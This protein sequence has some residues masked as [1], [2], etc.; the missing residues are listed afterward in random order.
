[1]KARTQQV[2]Q[3]MN[4]PESGSEGEGEDGD[5]SEGGSEAASSSF[6]QEGDGD[7]GG[8]L[9]D[10]KKAAVKIARDAYN[11]ALEMQKK[12]AEEAAKAEQKAKDADADAE[13]DKLKDEADDAAADADGKKA[14][15]DALE[16]AKEAS[17]V[18]KCIARVTKAADAE[19]S[20]VCPNMKGGQALI[21]ACFQRFVDTK[22]KEVDKCK[23]LAA[24]KAK[25]EAT[26][27]T[28]GNSTDTNSTDELDR[29]AIAAEAEEQAVRNGEE[30]R[31][32]LAEKAGDQAAG[33]EAAAAVEEKEKEKEA[34]QKEQAVEV[35]KREKAFEEKAKHAKKMCNAP[36]MVSA[37]FKWCS[38][39]GSAGQCLQS[40]DP[41][42]KCPGGEW[43]A[44][45][46]KQL[47][48]LNEHLRTLKEHQM[49]SDLGTLH[50]ALDGL[51]KQLG[52]PVTPYREAVEPQ[53][54]PT[55]YI[56][57]K[58]R[59][60]ALRTVVHS[61]ANKAG[62]P[63]VEEGE[64]DKPEG[65]SPVPLDANGNP[66]PL[67]WQVSP[68]SMGGEAATEASDDNKEGEDKVKMLRGT[69]P[70]ATNAVQ[71][72]LYYTLG[73][74][75]GRPK[76]G[77]GGVYTVA[78]QTL[79]NRL[80]ATPN[81]PAEQDIRKRL[82]W[83]IDVLQQRAS[84][85]TLKYQCA[86]SRARLTK[87]LEMSQK[88]T[89]DAQ[90]AL[91]QKILEGK[92]D[93][94]S[95]AKFKGMGGKLAGKDATKENA[96]KFK[97]MPPSCGC[98]DE[99]HPSCP[100]DACRPPPP[101]GCMKCPCQKGTVGVFGPQK[102]QLRPPVNCGDPGVVTN[103]ERKGNSFMEGAT[104]TFT[105]NIGFI[106]HGTSK[107]IC[108][109]NPKTPCVKCGKWSGEEFS[110]ER[111]LNW[112]DPS[113]AKDGPIGGH[114]FSV[115]G[116]L[117]F[118]VG[119]NVT[120]QC[121][122]N[123]QMDY[124]DKHLVCGADKQWIGRR[125]QCFPMQYPS[126]P[127]ERGYTKLV[128]SL[129]SGFYSAE[130]TKVGEVQDATAKAAQDRVKKAV[131]MAARALGG[132]ENLPGASVNITKKSDKEEQKDNNGE[133]EKKGHAA[134]RASGVDGSEAS[135]FGGDLDMDGS[136][137][138]AMSKFLE[139]EEGS[140]SVSGSLALLIKKADKAQE[141]LQRA[142]AGRHE[143]SAAVMDKVRKVKPMTPAAVEGSD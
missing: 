118:G 41:E 114:G 143:A 21:D 112:C 134:V 82:K 14:D 126:K 60:A 76:I 98:A 2:K 135:D 30:M 107:R 12:K 16:K 121:E 102:S 46:K 92:A 47:N 61:M 116:P 52:I 51:K 62:V 96:M 71:S 93:V 136:E 65:P 43:E 15:A 78:L 127:L 48:R 63:L 90:A 115:V 10:A 101:C 56:S 67:P 26:G 34:E 140:S 86:L 18:S 66:M 53:Q 109:A 141:A 79:I 133:K 128:D 24:K 29:L 50:G 81:Q 129:A 9:Y 85:A 54:G 7:G 100:C 87:A 64:E 45:L 84:N 120:M 104:M 33:M 25:G 42:T 131:D 124:G 69:P 94:S 40:W 117:K 58:K 32:K 1:M 119:A 3:E 88:A 19:A 122:E 17:A 139:Q 89:V 38:N 6:I 106:P 68:E 39:A 28:D 57:M 111:D 27:P 132:A 75:D 35:E 138:A 74:Y 123:Y 5:G 110:C 73:V 91:Q 113:E 55:D 8:P 37:G 130:H 80:A 95:M 31:T 125:P 23:E 97:N 22:D 72:D 99:Y 103:A 77:R 44:D 83:D 20:K 36:T 137:S 59:V 11:A 13:G 105:C 70:P 108:K 142:I 4:G 49:R